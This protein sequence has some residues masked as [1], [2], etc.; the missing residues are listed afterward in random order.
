MY[1][2]YLYLCLFS[3]LLFSLIFTGCSCNQTV[4][5]SVLSACTGE[6]QVKTADAANWVGGVVGAVLKDDDAVK[7]GA[8]GEASITFFDG[9]VIELR[10]NTQIEISELKQ[11][12]T[13][14][15]KVKQEIGE[16]WSKVEKL[17]DMAL[18]YEIET[19]VAVA[20]VRGS[21]M[22]VTVAT[23]GTTSVGNLEG[24]ISVTAQG[25]EVVIPEGK[26]SVVEP[27]APPSEPVDGTTSLIIST[28][29][30]IDSAGDL[31]DSQSLPV[32]GPDY[33]DIQTNQ[34]SFIEGKWVLRM[35]L[36]D[37]P[38]AADSVTA[39]TLIEWNFMLDFDQNPA[40]GLSRP[41]ISNDI[42]YDYLVQLSLEKNIY[43]CL[44]KSLA[45]ETTETIDYVITGNK[46][47]MVIPLTASEGTEI[48]SPPAIDWGT[49]AIYYKDEDPRDQPSYTDKAP[50]E[51]HYLFT[52]YQTMYSALNDFST[53][54]GNPNGVWSYGWMPVDF[55]TFNLYTS[56]ISNRWSGELAGDH[57]PCLWINNSGSTSYSV[58]NGWLSLHP[59]PGKEP[60]VLRWT[61]RGWGKYSDYR[62][63]FIR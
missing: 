26:H 56:R 50:G 28:Q 36:K 27:G 25:E 12:K 63:V 52:P 55:S 35:G 20:A 59:G 60:S 43:T 42:A 54:N 57:T 62:R 16:T 33:L 21:Q 2:K 45:E 39:N 4:G 51:G 53:E 46:I 18:R 14:S 40:T 22:I 44:L 1:H 23:D 48:L 49:C 9:S 30:Y 19:P 6:V 61:A 41:F 47:E 13:K 11:G 29:V 38:P 5:T 24:D 15:I 17:T 32:T 58:P 8:E 34:V 7:T 10:A 3:L 31:F 37:A